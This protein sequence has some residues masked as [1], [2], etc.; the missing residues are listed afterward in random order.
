[1][2]WLDDRFPRTMLAFWTSV[3]VYGLYQ[4]LTC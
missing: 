4:A 3:M 1:M 2:F